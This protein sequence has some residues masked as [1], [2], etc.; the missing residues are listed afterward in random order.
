MREQNYWVRRAAM[1]RLGRRRFLGGASAAGLGAAAF[2]LVGCGDDDDDGG[3]P[4]SAS[5]SPAA[6]T[7]GASPT[8]AAEQPYDGNV[9]QAIWL[10]GSQFDSVDVHR[11]FRDETSWLSNQILNK[12]VRYSNPDTGDREGDQC[13]P[14][15]RTGRGPVLVPFPYPAPP[16][17]GRPPPALSRERQSS[18]PPRGPAGRI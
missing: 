9:Y 13:P 11:N 18:P 14:L 8:A 5:G 17:R 1:Q 7:A 6:T 16:E 15:P 4:T 12:I 2:G 3:S 10:G